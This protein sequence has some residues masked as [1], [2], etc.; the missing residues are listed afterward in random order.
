MKVLE[1]LA[2]VTLTV[3][4]MYLTVYMKYSFASD[5]DNNSKYC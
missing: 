4:V 1:Y 3:T 5:P 2:L